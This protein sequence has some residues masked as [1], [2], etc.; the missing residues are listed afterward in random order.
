MLGHRRRIPIA[1]EELAHPVR[2]EIGVGAEH[3]RIGERAHLYQEEKRQDRGRDGPLAR[4]EPSAAVQGRSNQRRGGEGRGGEKRDV[5]RMRRKAH[6]LEREE[7]QE[8]DGQHDRGQSRDRKRQPGGESGAE[9]EN[10]RERH[11][12]SR[13]FERRELF[14][15]LQPDAEYLHSELAAPRGL[16]RLR[17]DPEPEPGRA[18]RDPE[19]IGHDPRESR[20]AVDGDPVRGESEA[21]KGRSRRP[22]RPQPDLRFDGSLRRQVL[23]HDVGGVVRPAEVLSFRPLPRMKPVDERSLVAPLEVD[24][25]RSAPLVDERG[26]REGESAHRGGHDQRSSRDHISM[27][28]PLRAS[29][30]LG[31]Q[32]SLSR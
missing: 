24:E 29:A 31:G 11:P 26:R 19:V 7:V 13:L 30:P 28:G 23:D 8:G 15:E 3:Q 4:M 22:D 21:R 2:L 10:R 25:D 14:R 16:E 9:K 20:R 1:L 27:R 17:F 12:E 18:R 6:R 32:S 5:P